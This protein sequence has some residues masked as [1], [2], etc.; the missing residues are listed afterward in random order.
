[1][2]LRE[3]MNGMDG[4]R[5]WRELIAKGISVELCRM[6]LFERVE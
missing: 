4:W 1:M 6:I 2:R 5:V 3:T